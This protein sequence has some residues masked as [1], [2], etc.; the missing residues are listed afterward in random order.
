M[1]EFE[2]VVKGITLL[3][4]TRPKTKVNPLK[5]DHFKGVLYLQKI[6]EFNVT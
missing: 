6:N 1:E 5:P 3:H 2:K 4:Q